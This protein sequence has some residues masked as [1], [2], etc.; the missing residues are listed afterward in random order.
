[1]KFHQ[2]VTQFWQTS[3]QKRQEFSLKK[4]RTNFRTKFED[5]YFMNK[6]FY[7]KKKDKI[8][9]KINKYIVF[10]IHTHT[11]NSRKIQGDFYTLH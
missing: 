5:E 6:S 11:H 4:N 8:N 7:E 1:M 10:Y 3:H 9:N 2:K